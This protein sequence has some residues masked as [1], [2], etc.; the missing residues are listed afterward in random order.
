[1]VALHEAHAATVHQHGAFAPH[2]FADEETLG[3]GVV[4][5]GRME[6]YELEIAQL[7]AG[8]E[9][10]RQTVACGD[11]GVARVQVDLAAA[12]GGQHHRVGQMQHDAVRAPVQHPG[13]DDAPGRRRRA[14]PTSLPRTSSSPRWSSSDTMF[15][16]AVAGGQQALFDLAPGQ[17]A[18]VQDTT[19]GV[20][21]LAPQR[22]AAAVGLAA[23]VHPVAEQPVDQARTRLDHLPDDVFPAQ[24]VAG[25]QGVLNMGFKIIEWR[26]CGGNAA[27]CV[28]RA[29]FAAFLLRD[30][31]H[32]P[33]FGRQQGELQAGDAL[34]RSPGNG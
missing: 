30:D 4:Q 26:D 7:G 9:G 3:L 33:A 2:R 21:T 17:V 10:H 16:C 18:A 15:A 5:A 22:E 34:N 20:A 8:T 11:V 13:A 25:G 6:L 29:A 24:A 23:E 27:L 12:T 32:R 31:P 14:G 28:V 19:L 1:M